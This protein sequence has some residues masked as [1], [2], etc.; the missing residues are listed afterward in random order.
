MY[1]IVAGLALVS[2]VLLPVPAARTQTTAVR[3]LNS[4]VRALRSERA[5]DRLAGLTYLAK[6][7]TKAKSA[8]RDV[9]LALYDPSE[10]VRKQALETL[11]VINPD[12]APW[13]AQLLKPTNNGDDLEDKFGGLKELARLGDKAAPAV[14][15]ILAFYRSQL[16]EGGSVGPG[17]I[18]A[19]SAVG[20]TDPA[21]AAFLA[22]I[23]VTAP[24]TN[25][26]EAAMMALAKQR[27]Q[28]GGIEVLK[29]AMAGDGDA[30]KKVRLVES[31]GVLAK[32]NDDA[33]RMLEGAVRGDQPLEVQRA[34]RKALENLRSK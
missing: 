14:P 17:F 13:I 33:Q 24:D 10:K 18:T 28:S 25:T 11:A 3:D 1:R 26:R 31:L 29:K 30:K 34:A 8:S 22:N 12:I 5:A 7:G 4:A 2:L 27:D 9:V 21:L 23:V 6:F 20:K 32:S 15:A 19:L 16:K